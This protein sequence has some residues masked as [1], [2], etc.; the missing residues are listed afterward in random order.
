MKK[1]KSIRNLSKIS[2]MDRKVKIAGWRL[3][4]LEKLACIA[5]PWLACGNQDFSYCIPTTVT[6]RAAHCANMIYA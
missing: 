3:L 2:L 4:S 5:C 6:V 1:K